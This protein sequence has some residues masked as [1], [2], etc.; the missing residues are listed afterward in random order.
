MDTIPQ[1]LTNIEQRVV[2]M[3]ESL[4][5]NLDFKA[6]IVSQ[7]GNTTSFYQPADGTDDDANA[8]ESNDDIQL[9]NIAST[10]TQILSQ[11]YSY[12]N[13][14]RAPS[15]ENPY[16]SPLQ[17]KKALNS[18]EPDISAKNIRVNVKLVSI[19][20]SSDTRLVLLNK[21]SLFVMFRNNLSK[22]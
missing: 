8:T 21:E 9:P 16:I 13:F 18:V 20:P 14:N 12:A 19:P 3:M 4:N 7:P 17:R 15:F 5:A 6:R 1:A 10:T 2:K 22:G 11:V